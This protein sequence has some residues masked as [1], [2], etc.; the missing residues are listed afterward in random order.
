MYFKIFDHIHLHIAIFQLGRPAR[1]VGLLKLSENQQLVWRYLF[2]RHIFFKDAIY[3]TQNLGEIA[4]G[5]FA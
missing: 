5:R 2:I 3:L 4:V 1:A